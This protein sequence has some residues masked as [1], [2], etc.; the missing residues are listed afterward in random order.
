MVKGKNLIPQSLNGRREIFDSRK[1]SKI[2]L[3]LTTPF[4]VMQLPLTH[5]HFQL[6]RMLSVN[7]AVSNIL[8]IH[9]NI[10]EKNAYLILFLCRPFSSLFFKLRILTTFHCA[11]SIR[12]LLVENEKKNAKKC[13]DQTAQSSAGTVSLFRFPLLIK[14]WTYDLVEPSGEVDVTLSLVLAPEQTALIAQIH[15]L[16][17]DLAALSLSLPKTSCESYAIFGWISL[18]FCLLDFHFNSAVLLLIAVLR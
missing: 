17:L 14:S 1:K 5:T 15:R 7:G 11:V 13:C 10:E 12:G 4:T 18:C 16:E 9:P 3:N 2:V 6:L 8:K